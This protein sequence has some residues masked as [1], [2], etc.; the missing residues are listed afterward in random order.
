MTEFPRRQIRRTG[1]RVTELG[2]GCAKL[3]GSQITAAL[4]GACLPQCAGARR[5]SRSTGRRGL[6]RADV[7]SQ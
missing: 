5:S 1:L 2:L 4:A 3:G 7:L 6:A